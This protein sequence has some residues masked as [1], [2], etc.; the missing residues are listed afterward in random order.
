MQFRRS[1]LSD[2]REQTAMAT[3]TVERRLEQ[4][5]GALLRDYASEE[6]ER[7]ARAQLENILDVQRR[8]DTTFPIRTVHSTC[9]HSNATSASAQLACNKGAVKK[10]CTNSHKKRIL[11][12]W[13]LVQI[14]FTAPL[15]H[16]SCADAE[17]AFECMHVECTVSPPPC[18][19]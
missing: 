10:I 17:V 4:L 19:T 6:G 16:A 5:M 7:S 12:L 2:R 11:F 3:E 15:L 18:A 13:L 1:A 9:M 8:S 14:F